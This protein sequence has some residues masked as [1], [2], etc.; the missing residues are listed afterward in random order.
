M[1]EIFGKTWSDVDFLVGDNCST[2]KCLENLA[3]VPL[4]G[5]ALHRLNLAVKCF[6]ESRNHI[7]KKIDDLM[8]QLGTLKNSAILKKLTGLRAIR[9]CPTRWS[10]TYNMLTRFLKIYSVIQYV[11]FDRDTVALVPSSSEINEVRQLVSILD[12]LKKVNLSL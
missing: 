12:D 7:L 11:S 5:C 4:V 3:G 2:N 9:R 6:C 1:L 8:S 10:S